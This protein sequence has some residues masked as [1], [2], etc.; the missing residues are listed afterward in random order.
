M[1]DDA[2]GSALERV[3][4]TSDVFQL[5]LARFVGYRS[6]GACGLVASSWQAEVLALLS[7]D[8]RGLVA[9]WKEHLMR[10]LAL[11]PPWPHEPDW[12]CF[13]HAPSGS[14]LEAKTA[15]ISAPQ[16]IVASFVHGEEM[17]GGYFIVHTQ[18]R[19]VSG[20]IVASEDGEYA[21]VL[22]LATVQRL[23]T[24]RSPGGPAWVQEGYP[25]VPHDCEVA[26]W[27]TYA[28]AIGACELSMPA[29]AAAADPFTAS[30]GV[31]VTRTGVEWG[32]GSNLW[33]IPLEEKSG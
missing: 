33:I 5:L 8:A 15:G 14:R 25:L 26:Q 16:L 2:L 32:S 12:L 9:I 22:S 21:A 10:D 27:H 24:A 20:N 6:L 28:D 23:S 30:R 18:Q 17:F 31:R 13:L 7:D 4:S 29:G 11:L 3:V 1:T 19:P